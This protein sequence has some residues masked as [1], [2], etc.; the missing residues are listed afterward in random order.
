M[1]SLHTWKHRSDRRLEVGSNIRNN[2][3]R[4]VYGSV[5][6]K[7]AH[8]P[9]P[10]GICHA[11]VILFWESCKCPTVG[12]GFHTKPPFGI[13]FHLKLDVLLKS[14]LKTYLFCCLFLIFCGP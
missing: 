13:L 8:P 4:G 9:P 12:P 7:R 11:F 5:N 1:A 2:Q 3:R 14:K 10:P 6:S